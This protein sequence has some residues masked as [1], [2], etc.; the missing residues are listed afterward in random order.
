MKFEV[1]V[2]SRNYKPY[3]DAS[4][5]KKFKTTGEVKTNYGLIR[6][7]ELNNVYLAI[8]FKDGVVYDGLTVVKNKKRDGYYPVGYTDE[9][10]NFE[11]VE[12][13]KEK[14]LKKLTY[15]KKYEDKIIED[16]KYPMKK[17]DNTDPLDAED[18]WSIRKLFYNKTGTEPKRILTLKL[19][20]GWWKNCI[21]DVFVIQRESRNNKDFVVAYDYIEPTETNEVFEIYGKAGETYILKPYAIK[22]LCDE[23]EAVRLIK[24]I[25]EDYEKIGFEVLDKEGYELLDKLNNLCYN[26]T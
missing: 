3:F 15:L 18:Y 24:V 6:I 22:H 21:I 12:T 17:E 19:E 13:S 1:F 16:V 11:L 8:L 14:L 7:Y 10:G 5:Y 23:K 4:L 26:N 9:V 25:K 2:Y 20:N